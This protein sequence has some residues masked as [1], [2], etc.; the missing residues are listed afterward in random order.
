MDKLVTIIRKPSGLFALVSQAKY[1]FKITLQ[2]SKGNSLKELANYY[3]CVELPLKL[4]DKKLFPT[5]DKLL[6]AWDYLSKVREFDEKTLAR[7]SLILQESQLDPFIELFDL[8]V[9]NLEQSEKILKPSAAHPRAYQG[10]KYQPP[11]TKQFKEINLHPYL[12]DEKNVNIILKQ[13]NLPSEKEIKFPKAFI[14]YL[15]PLLKAADKEKVFQFLEVFWTLRLDKKQNLLMHITRLLC[16][17]KNLSNV[18]R[19]C[20][21]VAKQPLR[22]RAI[23]ITLLIKLG[24]YLLSPTEHIEQYIDQFNLLTPKKY[25]VSRLFFFLLVI[26]K[27]INLDYIFVGFALANKYKKD[28]CFEH[29]SNTLPPPIEYIEK[30]D[31]YF[32]K[33]RYYSDRLALNIWDCCRVLE[34]F[35]DVISTINWQLLPIELAYDYINLYLNIK[36]Y[37]LEEEKLRLKWQFIKAQANKIDELLHSIDS[38][39]QEKFIKA[40]ADFYWRWDKISELKHS[41]DVLCFLLKRFCTT[42]FKEKTDFAETLSFLINFSDSSLQKV[43]AN[44]PNSS[45]LN[46][47]KDC[48]LEND[49]RL[50][51]DGIYVLV[52]MLPEFTINSFLNFSGLLLKV[53]KRIGTLS[54]PNRYFLVAE[55]KEHQI[56]T[57]DF[58]NIPLPSAFLI[59]ENT[60]NEKAFN[61][62]SD[63]FKNLVQQTGKAKSQ[64]LDH[65]KEKM[66]KDL[67]HT[68]LDI[69]EQLTVNKLQKGYVVVAVKLGKKL[70]KKLDYA[71]QFMNYIDLNRRPLRK[72]L[73]A[74]LRGDKDYLYNHSESQTW[75]K[76]HL[77]LDLSL[78]NQGI[79]FSKSSE[80]Y[81]MVSIEVEKDPLEVLKMGTYVGSCLGLGGRLTYSA[82]AVML[83]INKQV[84]YA[85][86]KKKQVIAR[87]LVAISEAK[88]LVCFEVYPNKL[89][90]EIKAM[91]RDY[92]KLFAKKLLIPLNRDENDEDDKDDSYKISNVISQDWWDDWAWDLNIDD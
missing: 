31:S 55:F 5:K 34:C 69:L 89:D 44:I 35:I 36:Y 75:L 25:Y 79:K 39:Y 47:E 26:K 29:F 78:W 88:T 43:L 16:L 14:K 92:D 73:K 22:R 21:I 87:Q 18:F 51:A 23:F 90:K 9:L 28:Y 86:N 30:L 49:S 42:P 61:P 74:Y 33:S 3:E 56:M 67:Y 60:V 63:K 15:L 10:T 81:G 77:Y 27:N 7:T 76:K 65:Y 64:L 13:F 57:T 66:F 1:K 37:D 11:K 50:I 58:L 2:D 32:R 41:F 48:Y 83:D 12:C 17:D 8:P 40:L 52:E 82:A 53:A 80:I 72:F 85:R 45:F 91:F 24:V 71:L 70:D 20:Q 46:L 59:L 6:N 54:E 38:L 62:V 68:K 4:L 19:W 84:L